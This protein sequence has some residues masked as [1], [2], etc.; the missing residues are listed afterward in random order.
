M[1]LGWHVRHHAGSRSY[2]FFQL[3]KRTQLLHQPSVRTALGARGCGFFELILWYRPPSS[4]IAALGDKVLHKKCPCG[5]K[6][7]QGH[8]H[9]AIYRC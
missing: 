7:L 2:I 4:A 9:V 1:L 5:E 6:S 3:K 8:F